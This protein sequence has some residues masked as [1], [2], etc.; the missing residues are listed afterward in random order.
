MSCQNI[1]IISYH[2]VSYIVWCHVMLWD[3]ISFLSYIISYRISYDMSSCNISF[4]IV[5]HMMSCN[6][7]SCDVI[8]IIYHII[9]YRI[10]YHMM[11]CHVMWYV[12]SYHIK[13]VKTFKRV[14]QATFYV[15]S[16][17]TSNK[18]KPLNKPYR[19]EGGFV[20]VKLTFI[21]FSHF[22]PTAH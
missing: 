20:S 8:Y 21:C 15:W 9:S 18:N 1:Y 5:Y 14:F 12:I 16:E 2:I 22:L 13:S 17:Q 11:P 10:V 7:M 3:V 6:V 4:R 19:H